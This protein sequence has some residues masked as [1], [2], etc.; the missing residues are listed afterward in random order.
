MN[1]IPFVL[2]ILLILSYGMAASFQGR[3]LSYRNQ[4]AYMGLR[5]A[6]LD[7]LRNS[8]MKQF[9]MLAGEPV[10]KERVQ[11]PPRE[12]K[13]SGPKE[14]STIE[15]PELNPLCAKLNLHPLVTEGREAHAALYET[16]A[17][18]L[19]IFYQKPCFPTE[20]RF[21]YKLL[22]AILAGAKTKMGE[23]TILPLETIAVKDPLLQPTYYK[24]L[25]GMKQYELSE[26]GYPP[27]IDYWKIEKETK[28]ICLFHCNKEMLTVFF[29]P[30]TT[31]KL[32]TELHDES[33][34]AGLTLEAI[35]TWSTD[36]EL[37]FVPQ[38]VWDLIDFNR[39]Q[40][41]ESRR[42]TL[43]GSEDG[44]SLRKDVVIR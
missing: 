42:E 28:K 10:K 37:P 9:K 29:G 7:L 41:G 18:M 22:D 30:K 2:T 3:L 19:R 11:H 38:E 40:H 33:K 17:K 26:A 14:S 44:V 34:K 36:P 24:F 6:E 1:I 13:K 27:L 12:R 32:Y 5:G 16:A 15:M 8:E 35:L 31:P 20:A 39:P 21:E 43:L 23:K 4:K 25:K